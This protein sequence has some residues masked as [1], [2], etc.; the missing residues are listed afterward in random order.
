MKGE[1]LSEDEG[2]APVSETSARALTVRGRIG[3]ASARSKHMHEGALERGRLDRDEMLKRS[4]E[5]LEAAWKKRPD[6]TTEI[7]SCQPQRLR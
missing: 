4:R 7:Y 1:R 2:E 3:R 5:G 6:S